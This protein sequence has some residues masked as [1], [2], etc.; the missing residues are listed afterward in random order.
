MRLFAV[1]PSK[2]VG[3]AGG[4]ETKPEPTWKEEISMQEA[5]S[6]LE[7]TFYPFKEVCVLL[8]CL[9]QELIVAVLLFLWVL[10]PLS[11]ICCLQCINCCVSACS[12]L[13]KWIMPLPWS[14]LSVHADS[15]PPLYRCL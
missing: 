10:S 13:P 5:E 8:H 11:A 6:I 2:A 3:A 12:C 4:A 15:I 9:R 14:C 1:A 7:R